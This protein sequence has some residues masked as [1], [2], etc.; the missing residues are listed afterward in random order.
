MSDHPPSTV[1]SAPVVVL[2]AGSSDRY[3]ASGGIGPKQLAVIGTTTLVQYTIDRIQAH[4]RAP[5]FAVV[6]PGRN[7]LNIAAAIAG[8][9]VTPTVAQRA[10][11][12]LHESA[13]HGLQ[14]AA[15]HGACEAILVLGDD[16]QAA[17]DLPRI[18][19]AAN[20]SDARI[21]AADRPHGGPHPILFRD[22]LLV[23]H[24][25][26]GMGGLKSNPRVMWI[27]LGPTRDVDTLNDLVVLQS[28]LRRS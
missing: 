9:R 23:T 15:K 27:P 25:D 11:E 6:A 17:D 12:G 19:E 26:L 1:D 16:P 28:E 22:P 14:F 13:L 5:I 24:T 8:D 7:G 2:M 4:T 3:R 18:I 20:D 10:S 21:V